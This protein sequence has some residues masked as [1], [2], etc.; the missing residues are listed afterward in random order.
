MKWLAHALVVILPLLT[1]QP[2][3]ADWAYTRWGMSPDEVAR[4]SGGPVS[5]HARQA[6]YSSEGHDALA[7]GSYSAAGFEFDVH[8]L[9]SKDN[10]GLSHVTLSV[11]PV[12]RCTELLWTLKDIYGLPEEQADEPASHGFAAIQVAARRDRLRGNHVSL[13]RIGPP[14]APTLCNLTYRPL[15]GASGGL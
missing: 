15:R 2:A 9:F 12:S 5:T 8:F 11:R 6:H 7:S 1:A 14:D 4:A 10:R 13:L 3:I